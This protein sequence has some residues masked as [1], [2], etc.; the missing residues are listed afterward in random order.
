MQM[1]NIDTRFLLV[2]DI[3]S[4]SYI[5]D[6]VINRALKLKIKTIIQLGDFWS[7][8]YNSVDSY[9]AKKYHDDGGHIYFIPGNHEQWDYLDSLSKKEPYKINDVLTYLPVGSLLK[10]GDKTILCVGKAP[11][12]DKNL[13]TSGL[14]WFPQETLNDDDIYTCLKNSENEKIDIIL[15]HEK[16]NFSHIPSEAL[17]E[18]VL[19]EELESYLETSSKRLDTICDKLKPF[20]VFHGHYHYFYNTITKRKDYSC[21]VIGLAA[22]GRANSVVVYDSLW[23]EYDVVEL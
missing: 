21:H 23:S 2:G 14:D 17:L 16:P 18:V 5:L 9:M 13:R 7:Y 22:D 4:S 6:D 1:I 8:D 11:S 3:H 20:H 12:I 15:S 19:G 10:S